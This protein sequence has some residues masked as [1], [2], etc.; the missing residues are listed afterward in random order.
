MQY[1]AAE[2]VR[3]MIGPGREGSNCVAKAWNKIKGRVKKMKRTVEA[4]P[5][6]ALNMRVM[7]AA[8]RQRAKVR[9]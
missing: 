4:V 1:A 3:N 9:V 8:A 7:I 2:S 5:M 6:A